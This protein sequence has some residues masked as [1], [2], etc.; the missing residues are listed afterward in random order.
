[1]TRSLIPPEAMYFTYKA[2]NKSEFFEQRGNFFDVTRSSIIMLLGIN[3]DVPEGH[4]SHKTMRIRD[5]QE[6]YCDQTL[7][8]TCVGQVRIVDLI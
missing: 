6:Y 1:M 8:I 4:C 5:V 3:Y 7:M 2:R